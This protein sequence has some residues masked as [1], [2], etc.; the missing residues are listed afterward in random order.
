MN[1]TRK[2]VHT[3]EPSMMEMILKTPHSLK[4]IDPVKKTLLLVNKADLLE[5]KQLSSSDLISLLKRI[6]HISDEPGTKKLIV[7]MVGYPNVG[8][9]S[10]INKLAG[11]KKVSVRLIYLLVDVIIDCLIGDY[12]SCVSVIAQVSSCHRLHLEGMKCSST[13]GYE[14]INTLEIMYALFNYRSFS[15]CD[16]CDLISNFSY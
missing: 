14:F 8:K 16:V 12:F 7:G 1:E 5:S 4:L 13:V 11:G 3:K 10:T 2:G 6:G 15:D 9:S